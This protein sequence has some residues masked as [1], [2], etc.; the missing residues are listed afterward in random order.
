[1]SEY[2][3]VRVTAQPALNMRNVPGGTVIQKLPYGAV[4]DLSD[5]PEQGEWAGVIWQGKQG[6]CLKEYLY[7]ITEEEASQTNVQWDETFESKFSYSTASGSQNLPYVVMQ[8]TLKE[9][10]IGT[11]SRNLSELEEVINHYA[12]RGYRLHTLSTVTS[13][14][15]GGLGGE[16]IQATLVFEKK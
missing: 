1:M 16:R 4:A 11:G 10:F 3:K 12:A 13:G 15:M 7:P 6:Y 9:K 8:V 5:W 2:K 14:N